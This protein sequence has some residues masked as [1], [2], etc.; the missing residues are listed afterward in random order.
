MKS[1]KNL[2][3]IYFF[4]NFKKGKYFCELT[5]WQPFWALFKKYSPTFRRRKKL[6]LILNLNLP[7]LENNWLNLVS[8]NI[9]HIYFIESS[10]IYWLNFWFNCGF[11]Q[12]GEIKT[13]CGTA[14]VL[15]G[16]ALKK[17]IIE[18]HQNAVFNSQ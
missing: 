10:R 7:S 15:Q 13:K 18:K 9:R 12:D 6:I 4:P 16:V 1:K 2:I 14:V 8:L 5:F 11:H 3:K 17:K